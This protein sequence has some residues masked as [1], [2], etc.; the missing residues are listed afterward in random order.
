MTKKEE[1]LT[2]IE[3]INEETERLKTFEKIVTS[4][5]D[6]T[7]INDNDFGYKTF[8]T[9]NANLSNLITNG[10]NDDLIGSVGNDPNIIEILEWFKISK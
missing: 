4:S 7:L 2:F 8:K 3:S 1:L 9:T 6:S 5:V 10:F